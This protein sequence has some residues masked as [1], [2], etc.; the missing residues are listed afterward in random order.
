M[1]DLMIAV[2]AV[3]SGCVVTL[4][5]L[6]PVA[7]RI[8][9]VDRPG[10][11]KI[12]R[13]NIPLVGGVALYGGLMYALLDME[14]LSDPAVMLAGTGTFILLVGLVDDVVELPS[15]TRLALQVLAALVLAAPGGV[16]I[17]SFGDLLA[18]GRA[19][20]TGWLAVPATVF[21]V[22]GVTNAINMSDGADGLAGT[23]A[24]VPLMGLALLAA[25]AGE[26]E[27]MRLFSVCAAAV[28]AFL[29]FNMRL[30]GRQHALVF[31]GDSGS[32]L[33]GLLLGSFMVYF[34]QGPNALFTP[35]TALWLVA[36]PL[37]DT[38]ARMTWRIREGR[39]PFH[40][41]REH[42]HHIMMRAGFSV[43]RTVGVIAAWSV[44]CAVIGIAG[45]LAGVPEFL[46]FY[47]FMI[48]SFAYLA[49]MARAWTKREFL[50][51]AVRDLEEYPW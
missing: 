2:G 4:F 36:P 16:V 27:M 35:V 11:H 21:C 26:A 3:F 1:V 17:S 45:Y 46:M 13:K 34:S 15:R 30:P 33:L 47:A 28:V 37:I 44:A 6:R 20:E 24:L 38:V 50:G 5:A 25:V 32:M 10:S 39:S 8:S 51:R 9:F 12:H 19:L 42:L 48:M 14:R 31:M 41:D 7:E 29:L 18:P 22:V 40:A 43:S 23:L 49:L